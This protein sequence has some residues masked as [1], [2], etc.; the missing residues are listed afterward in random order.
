MDPNP[1]ANPVNPQQPTQPAAQQP[2]QTPQYAQQPYGQ[3]APQS[4]AQPAQPQYG[5]QVPPQQAAQPTTSVDVD[6]LKNQAVDLS[7]K[8]E[9]KTVAV[10]GR[11]FSYVTV[12]AAAAAVLTL[13]AGFL[14]LATLSIPIVGS[15]SISSLFQQSDGWIF[16]V[17]AV[18]TVVLDVFRKYLAGL[19]VSAVMAVMVIVDMVNFSN[20]LEKV[21]AQHNLSYYGASAS[22]GIGVWLALIAAIVLVLCETIA[23]VNDLA[24]KKAAAGAPAAA[25][26]PAPAFA[27]PFA[28]A[29][30][31]APQ[32]PVAP[33]AAPV[34]Q[35]APTAPAAPA[36]AAQPQQ[37]YAPQPPAAPQVPTDPNGPVAQ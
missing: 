24:A 27:Q 1:N 19:I 8:L 29:Q 28:A 4:A 21:A 20:N 36:P 37:P 16:L 9:S 32:Q 2:Q 11:T 3:Q 35:P 12:A 30:P 7:R 17:L 34:A 18:A 13:I 26:A 31:A 23:F 15:Q 10:G 22:I 6:Q 25:S 5:Q 33:V 14:P